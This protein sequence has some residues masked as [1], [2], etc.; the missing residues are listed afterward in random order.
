MPDWNCWKISKKGFITGQFICMNQS[1]MSL[2]F[3]LLQLY[4]AV[5]FV[6]HYNYK[7]GIKKNRPPQWTENVAIYSWTAWP[8]WGRSL[9]HGKRTEKCPSNRSPPTKNREWKKRQ[10][11]HFVSIICQKNTVLSLSLLFPLNFRFAPFFS[12]YGYIDTGANKLT[13]IFLLRKEC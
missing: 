10:G 11:R 12:I 4:S 8:I 6:H 3:L 7:F 9:S 2:F 5:A 13:I 1:A